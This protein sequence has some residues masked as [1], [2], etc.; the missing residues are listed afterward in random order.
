M[1]CPGSPPAPDGPVA[2]TPTPTPMPTPVLTPTPTTPI[3]P[4]DPSLLG[5]SQPQCEFG[6]NPETRL[7]NTEDIPTEPLTPIQEPSTPTPE[8]TTTQ[9]EEF[10]TEEEPE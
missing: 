9:D 2:Q 8:P 1:G 10:S 5:R 7:C 3:P 6:V 4:V